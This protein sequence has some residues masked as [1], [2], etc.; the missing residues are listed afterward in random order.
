MGMPVKIRILVAITNYG[1]KNNEYL[2]RLIQEYQSMPCTIDIVV[3]SNIPKE[4]EGEVEVVVGLPTKNPWSLPFMHNKIFVDRLEDYDLFIYSEDDM[5]IT[6]K[7]IETFIHHTKVLPEYDISGFLQYELDANGHIWYPAFLG[8]YHWL[9]KSVHKVDHFTFAE[10]SNA[11]SACYILTRDQLRKAIDSGGYP[12]EPHQGRYDLLC[13]AA[14]D[15]Y[16]QCGFK[17]VICISHISDM[18]VHHLPNKYVGVW[19]IDEND[20]DRQRKLMLSLVN[21]GKTPQELII[22]TK[23]INDVRWDKMYFNRPDHDLLSLVSQK[24]RTVLSIGCGYPSTE[25]Y[26]VQNNRAVTAIPL[27]PVIGALAAS[28]GIKV[29][30]PD[31]E[32]AFNDLDGTLFDCI[33]FSDVLQHIE[34]PADI[35]SRAVELLAP[36]GE[37]LVSVPN[38]KYLK[39]LKDHFPYPIFKRWTYSENLLHMI[40]KNHLVKWFRSIGLK[41]IDLRYVVESQRLKKLRPSFGMFNALFAKRLLVRGK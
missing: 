19:G 26:L 25:A 14:T 2:R 9:P 36:D 15:P 35:L 17:K 20:F 3:L 34:D 29:M 27:D 21:S 1:T 23:K 5:L 16:T 7:N 12:V 10:F 30:K 24:A 32:K 39:F 31:F 37:V 13:S 6:W 41:N 4:F 8:P 11:H 33:I 38:F 22:S 18:L 28:K 40:D